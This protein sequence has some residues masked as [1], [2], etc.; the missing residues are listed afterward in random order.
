MKI[1]IS[2]FLL[3]YEIDDLERIVNQLKLGSTLL[4][5]KN[6]WLLDVNLCLADDMVNWPASSIPKDY[7]LN[8]LRAISRKADWCEARFTCHDHI[9][10]CVSHRRHSFNSNTDAD[11]FVWLDGDIIFSERIL[12]FLEQGAEKL[13]QMSPLAILTPEIVR[14]WDSTWDCL[15]NE[16][17][18]SKPIGY[19]ATNDPFHD[20]GVKGPV[21]LESVTNKIPGQPRFKFAGGWFTC[22]SAPLLQ[23]TGI[24]ES[25][26]HYG[27][28][29]TFV[30]WAAEKL[31]SRG[32]DFVAQYKM[33]NLVVCENY[34]YRDYG[35]M[36]DMVV[37]KNRKDEFKKLSQE[38]FSMELEKV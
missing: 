16:R 36:N 4:S 14:V 25:F 38:N 37:I 12:T 20:A 22:L 8:R 19:Q 29:D 33:K 18:L 26:G 1:V 6:H 15:V 21:S 28:E 27:L 17:Y 31:V 34:K 24:P 5:G 13:V 35:Y 10:G 3:P 2:I 32:I 7:F 23:K 11:F 30:M 9:K